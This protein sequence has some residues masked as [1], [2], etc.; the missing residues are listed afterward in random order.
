M[1]EDVYEE[2]IVDVVGPE[3]LLCNPFIVK[4]AKYQLSLLSTSNLFE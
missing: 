3:T 2:A 1:S 4:V